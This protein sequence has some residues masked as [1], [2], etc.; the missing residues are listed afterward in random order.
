[1]SCDV[2]KGSSNDGDTRIDRKLQ[3]NACKIIPPNIDHMISNHADDIPGAMRR[4]VIDAMG[5]LKI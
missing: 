3:L 1:M 2:S 5:S 4:G